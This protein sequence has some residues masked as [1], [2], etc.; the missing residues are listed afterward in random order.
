MPNCGS[1]ESQEGS[2]PIAAQ[3]NEP[4]DKSGKVFP[5]FWE[6]NVTHFWSKR[7]NIYRFFGISG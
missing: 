3:G 4:V 5:L 2:L 6:M 1:A 7:E